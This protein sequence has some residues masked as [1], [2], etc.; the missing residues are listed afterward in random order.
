[1]VEI[2]DIRDKI[3]QI[4][5]HIMELLDI[6]FNYTNEIGRL[7]REENITILDTNREN[8][9]IEKASKFSHSPQIEHIYKTIMEESKKL[10]GK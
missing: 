4:D 3:N 5:A 6:R 8:I 9:I 2:K 7:K 1:M 10:Q